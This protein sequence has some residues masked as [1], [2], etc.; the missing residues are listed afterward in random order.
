M[1]AAVLAWRTDPAAHDELLDRLVDAMGRGQ[2]VAVHVER[3]LDAALDDAWRRGWAPADVVHFAAH[4]LSVA[5]ADVAAEAALTDARARQDAGITV[6]PAWRAQLDAVAARRGVGDVRA[7]D[8]ALRL[9]VAALCLLT[10]LFDVPPTVPR[11]EQPPDAAGHDSARMD[12]ARPNAADPNAFYADTAGLDQRMLARVRALLAKAES[13]AFDQEAE[14]LMAKAQELIARHAIAD[15][16]LHRADDIGEPAVR[17]VLLDPPYVDAKAL[18]LSKIGD[19]NRCRTVISIDCNWV[20]V[21]GFDRD[22]DALE[23]LGASLLT[24]ATGAMLRH[25][26]RTDVHGRSR[27]RSFR[28]AFLMGFAQRIG[29]RLQAATDD[30][31]AAAT[32]E[33]GALLP[34]LAARDDR[35]E[36]VVRTAFPHLRSR[37][38]S[39]GSAIG[40][41]AG[42]AAAD[43]ADLTMSAGRLRP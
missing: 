26:S 10:R 38:S 15:A 39:V 21:F 6:H 4:Q 2:P 12:A 19:A 3:R 14:A 43:H 25:G 8:T 42:K 18:L 29:E 27:T 41:S 16:L 32:S 23:L 31:V 34:V 40:W 36:A 33:H 1:H 9:S 37:A 30:T 20:T 28:R 35:V 22:L 24:Q 5:H 11:P 13:T 17:R 7:P